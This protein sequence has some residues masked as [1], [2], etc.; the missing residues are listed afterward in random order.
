M[1]AQFELYWLEIRP[2]KSKLNTKEKPTY[3]RYKKGGC[4]ASSG[5][6]KIGFSPNPWIGMG[7][8]FSNGLEVK[9]K[10]DASTIQPSID[11]LLKLMWF[12]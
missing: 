4:M 11:A 8:I 9:I 3:P 12:L 2:A 6:C 7:K 5:S 1:A 10:K